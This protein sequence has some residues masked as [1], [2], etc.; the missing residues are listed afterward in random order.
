MSKVKKLL[1]IVL[2]LAMI[3]GMSVTTF[4]EGQTPTADDKHNATVKNVEEGATVTAYQIVKADY[5][6]TGFIGYKAVDGVTIA[7]PNA[8]TSDEVTAIATAIN[9]G[10]VSLTS[11]SMNQGE[12]S[13][14]YADYTADLNAGY[15]IVLVTGTNI[16]EVYNPMLVGVYYSVSGS[17]DTMTSQPIDAND[18]WKLGAEIAYAKSTKPVIEKTVGTGQNDVAIGDDVDFTITTAI[19]SYSKQYKAVKVVISDSLSKGLTLETESIKISVGGET[20]TPGEALVATTEGFTLTFPSEYALSNSGK[21][22]VITY[23]AELNDQAG[24]NFDANTNTATLEYSNNPSNMNDTE[25]ISDKTYTYTFGIDPSLY[26]SSE[27]LNYETSELIKVDE[28]GNVI[29]KVTEI[30]ENPPEGK[31]EVLTG[32]TFTLTNN[33]TNKVYTATTDVNGKMKF[34]GLDAGTYTLVETAAPSG[35]TVDTTP[36]KVEIT[37]QYY[38]SEPNKG[39]LEYYSITIDGEVTSTYTA[40]YEGG[41]ITNIDKDTHTT[42]IKNSKLATLPSTGGIGTTIFTIGGCVIMIAAAGLYFA[43][44]RRQENK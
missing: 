21:S 18:N 17:D 35:F 8:P 15:W 43:S 30:S 40:T 39:L 29:S 27:T 2:A 36:H 1:A 23:K 3:M 25:K 20:Y 16:V 9:N 28:N 7:K 11:V 10:S 19:P 24:I 41:T 4:A 14:G 12:A 34:E 33:A 5:N 44:R 22:V 37:A 31:T 13:N 38:E 26:A 32:A 6:N 42:E